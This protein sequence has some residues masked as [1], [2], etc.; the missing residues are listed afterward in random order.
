[1][2]AITRKLIYTKHVIISIVKLVHANRQNY[3][4]KSCGI[5]SDFTAILLVMAFFPLRHWLSFYSRLG[6]L[7][8][9]SFRKVQRTAAFIGKRSKLNSISF[10]KLDSQKLISGSYVIFCVELRRYNVR[11]PYTSGLSQNNETP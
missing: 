7:P 4:L 11:H 3:H 10:C 9:Q 5:C 2:N 6:F 8:T 1:M